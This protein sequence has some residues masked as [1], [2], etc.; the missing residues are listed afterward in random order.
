MTKPIVISAGGTGGHIFPAQSLAA[1]LAKRGRRIVLMTDPRGQN[2]TQSFPNAEIATVPSATFAGRGFFGKGAALV[3]LA[4]G[5][6]RAYGLLGKIKPGCVVGFGG[7]PSMPGLVAATQR[8]MPTLIHEQNAILGRVNRFLA[9]RVTAIAA[10][11]PGMERVPAG[12]TQ[13][14]MVTGNPVRDT[15]LALTDLAYVGPQPGEPFRVLIFGGSQ[16]ARVF[17]QLLPQAIAAMLPGVK[18]RLRLEQ[19]CR[20]EDI[21]AVRAEYARMGVQAELATFFT[22]M[23]ARLTRAHLV[24]CRAGASTV[25]ELLALGRPALLVPYPFAMDDHQSANARVLSQ[26]GAA[27]TVEEKGLNAQTLAETIAQM[28]AEPSRLTSL[29]QSAKAMGRLNAAAALADM[30]EGLAEGRSVAELR[31]RPESV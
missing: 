31:L 17:S 29:A 16:G 2:Y 23:G 19:Q 24:V 11:F 8:G 15:V 18:S 25:T 28:A 12:C 3:T 14:V 7:Y 21:D 27:L 10:T 6:M 4:R 22:D 9:P 1:E 13:K 20:P 5:A 30:A 26:Q